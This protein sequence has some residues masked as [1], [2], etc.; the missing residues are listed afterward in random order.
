MNK[1]TL[2]ALLGTVDACW[3]ADLLHHC[4]HGHHDHH[5]FHQSADCQIPDEDK[6]ANHEIIRQIAQKSYIQ[7]VRGMY[8]EQYDPISQ[9]CF[10][11]WAEPTY[12]NLKALGHQFHEDKD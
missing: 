6:L 5:I 11:D 10:G 2:L 3:I 8:N 4:H 12:Q 9:E 1:L 7:S